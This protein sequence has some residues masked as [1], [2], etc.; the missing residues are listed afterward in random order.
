[1]IGSI[2]D[3]LHTENNYE[4]KFTSFLQCLH[5]ILNMLSYTLESAELQIKKY[6][7]EN[8]Q[9]YEYDWHFYIKNGL[10][11]LFDV[12]IRFLHTASIFICLSAQTHSRSVYDERSYN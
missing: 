3:T 5:G 4:S 2:V 8:K 12:S 11:N 6:T 10:H 1:M 9:N 7:S